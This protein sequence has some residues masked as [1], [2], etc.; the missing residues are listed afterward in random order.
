V[1]TVAGQSSNAGIASV[2]HA[3][4]MPEGGQELVLFGASFGTSGQVNVGAQMCAVVAGGWSHAAVRCITPA[5]AGEAAAVDVTVTVAGQVS[6][7]VPAIYQLTPGIRVMADEV[8]F[9]SSN[10]GQPTTAALVVANDG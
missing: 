9:A 3:E 4:L 7:G 8:A 2:S 6:N 5:F 10:I 1:V